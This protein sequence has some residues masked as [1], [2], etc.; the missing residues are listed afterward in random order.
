MSALLEADDTSFETL[1]V[2]EPKPV[3]VDFSAT[4]CGPCKKLT[5]I[6]DEIAAEFDG[7]LKVVKVDVDRAPVTAMKYAVLSV[8]T[9]LLFRG[10]QVKDQ[11]IGLLPK[12]ALAE[13]V[14]RVL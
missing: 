9:L 7:R 4:W 10:G 12:K 5:P 6:V 11:I 3:L 1:V 13:R 14:Q 2:A 8:P